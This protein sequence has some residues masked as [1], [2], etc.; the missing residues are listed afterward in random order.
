MKKLLLVMCLYLNASAG[1]MMFAA[2]SHSKIGDCVDYNKY[3]Y[4]LDNKV[5]QGECKHTKPFG[6]F[7]LYRCVFE[8]LYDEDIVTFASYS[9]E[10]ECEKMVEIS[11]DSGGEL[12][13]GLTINV[14][15]RIGK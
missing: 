8:G 7:D 9:Q 11:K 3:K 13:N 15:S 2:A 12:V 4:I 10:K 5:S 1:Y 6:A 14:L